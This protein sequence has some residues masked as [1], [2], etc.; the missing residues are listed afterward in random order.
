M[1]AFIVFSI[2]I[3]LSGCQW[4]NSDLGDSYYYLDSYEAVD[5]GF[6]DG[7]VIYKSSTKNLYQ[8]IKITKQVVQVSHNDR[9]ILVKQ[10]TNKDR[11]D[12]NYFII[13]KKYDIVYGPM[14]LN[15]FTKIKSFLKIE[16][17]E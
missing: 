7:A 16:I 10:L 5:V 1:K 12:T 9:F 11:L 14:N 4:S 15:S 17:N 3:L 13:H 6:P 8:E 2:S